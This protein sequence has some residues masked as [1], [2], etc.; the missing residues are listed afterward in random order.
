MEKLNGLGGHRLPL[1]HCQRRGADGAVERPQSGIHHRRSAA[2][3]SKGVKAL[4]KGLEE[5]LAKGSKRSR[6][7]DLLRVEGAVQLVEDQ[8]ECLR[9][10]VQETQHHLVTRQRG[11][12]QR[13]EGRVGLGRALWI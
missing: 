13:L 10:P 7:D 12:K 1:V 9:D 6:Q 11:L 4:F 2:G 8:A 3:G 5:T